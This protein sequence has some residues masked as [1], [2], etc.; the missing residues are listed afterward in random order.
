MGFPW[1]GKGAPRG[2]RSWDPP[3]SAPELGALQG[4]AG[5]ACGQRLWLGL[6]RPQGPLRSSIRGCPLGLSTSASP[7]PGQASPPS[8]RPLW[9]S[10]TFSAHL[11]HPLGR[12]GSGGA[13][14]RKPRPAPPGL[15][16]DPAGR[17]H[18]LPPS[19]QPPHHRPCELWGRQRHTQAP[20]ASL[21]LTPGPVRAARWPP[22]TAC[23]AGGGRRPVKLGSA[24][25]ARLLGAEWCQVPVSPSVPS[26]PSLLGAPAPCLC[27][28]AGAVGAWLQTA[29]H[30]EGAQG[31]RAQPGGLGD[32]P[33][34]S[35]VVVRSRAKC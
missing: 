12:R 32:G 3:P 1:G 9:S 4:L 35:G 8:L 11:P 5:S 2:Q 21:G 34:S 29:R 20:L 13:L 16:C 18:P 27:S 7:S 24:A 22:G 28:P 33:G 26:P 14:L 25:G 6:T 17:L 31:V 23:R 30:S 19:Q 10:V 15:C